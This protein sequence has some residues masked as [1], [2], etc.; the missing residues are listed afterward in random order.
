MTAPRIPNLRRAISRPNG[1][2][3]IARLM[4]DI[5]TLI[6]RAPEPP[7]GCSHWLMDAENA[8]RRLRVLLEHI[9]ADR[10]C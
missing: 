5:T 6:A 3:A 10:L 1:R 9:Y 4:R 8:Q 2:K 7:S